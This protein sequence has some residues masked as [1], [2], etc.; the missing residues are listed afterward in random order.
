MVAIGSTARSLK[1]AQNLLTPVY[2]LCAAPTFIAGIGEMKLRGA[3]MLVP[4]MNVT[5]LAR[6]LCWATRASGRPWRCW[7]RRWHT[8]RWR[9]RWRRGLYDSERLLAA[10]EAGLGLRQWLRRLLRGSVPEEATATATAT[11]RSPRGRR[12]GTRW[13]CS[14]SPRP[15]LLRFLSAAGPRPGPGAPGLRMG[16]AAGLVVVYA[17]VTGRGVVETVQ[18]RRP[19]ARAVAGAVL[20]GL[21]AWAVI[22]LAGAVVRA[23]AEGAGRPPAP[24]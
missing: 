18:L 5:L 10:D 21:S 7:R 24:R 17:R 2:F 9:R 11:R 20:I 6:D 14:G 4:G 13:R 23:S 3:A 22:G 16:G 15:A 12:P 1:E 19:T 8:A